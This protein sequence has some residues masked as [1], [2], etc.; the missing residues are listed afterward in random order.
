MTVPAPFDDYRFR[1]YVYGPIPVVDGDARFNGFTFTSVPITDGDSVHSTYPVDGR[2]PSPGT[3]TRW[4]GGFPGDTTLG[5]GWANPAP[6]EVVFDGDNYDGTTPFPESVVAAQEGA[7]YRVSGSLDVLTDMTVVLQQGDDTV[8]AHTLSATGAFNHTF[9]GTVPASPE[10]NIKFIANPEFPPSTAAAEFSNVEFFHAPIFR[11]TPAIS[12]SAIIGQTLTCSTGNP[13]GRPAA[14]VTYQ[15]KR[16][17]GNI[18]GATNS[19]YLVD[20]ADYN[21]TITCEVTATNSEGAASLTAT[22]VG[23]IPGVAPSFL[24]Q[25]TISVTPA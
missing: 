19:T 24:T 12:G 17:G 22:G 14:T 18:G 2:F 21:T 15:W 16:D 10:N 23:P 5:S 8:N 13:I 4:D 1:Q 25:P 7:T 20:A 3:D 6:G 11:G 9:T